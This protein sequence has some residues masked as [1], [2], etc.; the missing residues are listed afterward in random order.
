MG[1]LWGIFDRHPQHTTLGYFPCAPGCRASLGD[2]RY[3]KCVCQG[4]NHGI[5]NYPR[6]ERPIPVPQGFNPH[7]ALQQAPEYP[8]LP[9]VPAQ[10]PEIKPKLQLNPVDRAVG[11]ATKSIGRK[12]G[13]S[14]KVSIA[15]YSQD[16]LNNSVL[17]GLSAQ[18]KPERVEQF[19]DLAFQEFGYRNPDANRPELYELF[20]S[21][22][23]DRALENEHVRW[24]IGRPKIRRGR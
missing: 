21:G 11:H 12:I 20:E 1:Y 2:P 19:V 22:Y 24:V 17:K 10:L 7:L 3:C 23:L 5:L 14:F 13:H 16:D 8:A 9:N 6:P 4:I 18:F 15:G